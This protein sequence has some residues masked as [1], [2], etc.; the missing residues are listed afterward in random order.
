MTSDRVRGKWRP[1]VVHSVRTAVTAVASL[2]TARLFRLPEAYWAAMTTLVITQSSL[3][4][5][6]LVSWQRFFGTVLGATVGAIAA[7][8]F[9]ANLLVFAAGVFV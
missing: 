1:V 9:G 7:H 5:A 6:L 3:G 8:Y 2:L 4:A